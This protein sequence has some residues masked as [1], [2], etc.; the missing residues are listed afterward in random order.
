MTCRT[1]SAALGVDELKGQTPALASRAMPAARAAPAMNPSANVRL[2]GGGLKKT[3]LADGFAV[4]TCCFWGQSP[5]PSYPEE[6]AQRNPTAEGGN[7][8]RR[9]R[10]DGHQGSK[11]H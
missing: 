11:S 1:S 4:L 8:H 10:Q 3:P 2:V 6:P 5:A 7:R 9:A